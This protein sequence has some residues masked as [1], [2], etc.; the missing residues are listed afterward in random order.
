MTPEIIGSIVRAVLTAVGGSLV[1]QGYLSADQLN[2]I[3]GGAVVA[4]TL[5]WSIVQKV[6]AKKAV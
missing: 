5:V 4:V 1:T 2:T 6:K 3:A